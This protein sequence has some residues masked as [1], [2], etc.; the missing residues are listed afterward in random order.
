[1][2]LE[3]KVWWFDDQP[4][5][6]TGTEDSLKTR[7]LRLGFK[8]HVKWIPKIGDLGSKLSE[9]EKTGR[10]DLILM[11]WQ[12]GGGNDGSIVAK[13]VRGR[14]RYSEIVFY[15]AESPRKLRE[16]IFNQDIDG[17]YCLHRNN[18]GAEIMG[19]VDTTLKKVLDLNHM[20]GVVMAYVSDLDKKMLDCINRCHCILDDEGKKL[21]VG[22]IKDYVRSI[23]ESELNKI[24][25]I[26]TENEFAE[27]IKL[28]SF[29]TTA[30]FS[31]LKKII[32]DERDLLSH[33]IDKFKKYDVE[34]VKPRNDLAHVCEK[35]EKG[36]IV[37]EC[38]GEVY[39]ESRLLQLRKEL[40]AHL[41]NLDDI[42]N[43]LE[44]GS[45]TAKI[46]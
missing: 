18:L 41:D 36:K 4:H 23:N 29:G 31:T 16:L 43:S 8:L 34:V 12:L 10:P 35:E 22:I 17:V 42:T 38:C 26:P 24:E 28:F 5:N 32:H 46:G 37:L 11:D 9:L 33:L 40:L 19:V 45:L 27:L 7:L 6:M 21:L 20:R 3:Y 39:D 14:F 30:R 15:S 44:T 2:K 1:M 25:N 13:A